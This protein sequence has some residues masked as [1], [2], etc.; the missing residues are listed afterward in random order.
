[1]RSHRKSSIMKIILVCIV[2]TILEFGTMTATQWSVPSQKPTIQSAIAAASSGDV[3][4][5]ASGTY[6]EATVAVNKSLRLVGAGTATVIT[7]GIT[8]S[9]DSVVLQSLRV[10]HTSSNGIY[11]NGVTNL[12]LLNVTSDSNASSGAQLTSVTGT[13]VV[14]NFSATGN[15][16]HGLSIG[17]GSS[18]ITINGG[19]FKYNGTGRGDGTGAGINMYASGGTIISRISIVGPITAS[20]NTTAGIWAYANDIHDTV[21]TIT[22]GSTG[23]VT[24]TNNGGAGVILFGNVKDAAITGNFTKSS[25]NAAG[26]LIVSTG[27]GTPYAPINTLIKKCIF[28]SG[29]WSSQPAISL[30]DFGEAVGFITFTSPYNVSADSNTFVGAPTLAAIDTLIYDNLDDSYDGLGLVELTHD[31]PLPVELTSFTASTE[32]RQIE[33]HWATATEVNNYGF[34]VERTATQP[35][36]MQGEGTGGRQWSVVAF[37]PG[38]GTTSALQ[39]Y[40]YNDAVQSA[41]TF[42]YRLEQID[43]DG[44]F[45]YSPVVDVSVTLMPDD[46][47]LS[48]NFPN[49]FNPT[50]RIHFALQTTQFA[51]VKVFNSLGEEV[52]TLFSGIG[53]AGVIN[54]VQFD[55]REFASGVYFYS[56]TV[57][58]R[59]EIKKMV[60]LK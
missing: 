18:S 31:N 2:S 49:P 3:I 35:S 48:Q 58:G 10:A 5:I 44:N 59:H 38:H 16:N 9:A 45:E 34:E 52:Q 55:G 39:L 57:K 43:H 36:P 32:G 54:E 19:T 33:L 11:A 21:K 23:S 17:G 50:T 56:L 46:Y 24:L 6:N 4:N 15:K 26:I 1:M 20:N 47:A 41:G 30:S 12:T 40:K 51:E 27:F 25:A 14:T 22:I 53:E 28:N 7:K 37:V 42:Q 60:L 29:Y 8:V 13:S